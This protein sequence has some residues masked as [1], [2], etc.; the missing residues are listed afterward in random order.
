[1]VAWSACVERVSGAKVAVWEALL[2]ADGFDLQGNASDVVQIDAKS[3]KITLRVFWSREDN[4]VCRFV[5]LCRLIAPY[6]TPVFCVQL[7]WYQRRHDRALH[8][9]VCRVRSV[10]S[11]LFG[12]VGCFWSEEL[13]PCEGSEVRTSPFTLQGAVLSVC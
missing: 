8:F 12:A 10:V 4:T 13:N 11:S 3:I 7:R 9:L 1:M 2:E 5:E 6:H